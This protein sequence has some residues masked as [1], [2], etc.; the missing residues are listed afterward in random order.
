PRAWLEQ[1]KK[2]SVKNAPTYFGPFAYEIVSDVDNGKITATV[3]MPSRKPAHAV[4]LRLRHPKSASIKS[5]TVNG[6][7]WQDFDPAKEVIRLHDMQGEVK[8]EAAY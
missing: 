8:V 2:I 4:L 3:E 7:P 6:K 5:V 1:G